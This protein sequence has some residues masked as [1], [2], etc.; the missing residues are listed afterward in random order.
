MDVIKLLRDGLPNKVIARRLDMAEATVKVHVREIMRKI[1]AQNR[2]QVA[3]YL[4]PRPT[5]RKE[6]SAKLKVFVGSQTEAQ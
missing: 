3:L 5:V 6:S 1:G 2:T 4:A